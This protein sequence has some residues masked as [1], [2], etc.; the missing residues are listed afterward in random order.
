MAQQRI[1]PLPV[2]SFHHWRFNM[3]TF[4]NLHNQWK[5]VYYPSALRPQHVQSIL[6][7]K[8][9][10]VEREEKA[11]R[12]R[13][14][15]ALRAWDANAGKAPTVAQLLPALEGLNRVALHDVASGNMFDIVAAFPQLSAAVGADV[16][17][18]YSAP[19][20]VEMLLRVETDYDVPQAFKR[21]GDWGGH[22]RCRSASQLLDSVTTTGAASILHVN[23]AMRTHLTGGFDEATRVHKHLYDLIGMCRLLP[24]ADTYHL[25]MQ[26]LCLTGNP[27]DADAIFRFLRTNHADHVTVDM[28]H[29][30][31]WGWR[32]E[33]AYD[34]CDELW[35]ELVDRRVPRATP[36]IA[37]EYIRGIVE[38]SNAPV[39]ATATQ[40]GQ[41]HTVERKRI[42]IVLKQMETLGVPRAHLTPPVVHHVEQALRDFRMY[43][44]RFYNWGR[45][46]KQFDFLNYRRRVGVTS[47]VSEVNP[48]VTQAPRWVDR[49]NPNAAFAPALTAE[50]P[51]SLAM[52][53]SWELTPLEHVLNTVETNEVNQHRGVDK[54]QRTSTS[55]HQRSANWSNMVPETRYD[56]L[57]GMT[58]TNMSKLG[59]RRHLYG[60]EPSKQDLRAR[61]AAVVRDTLSSARRVRQSVERERT[62]RS[63]K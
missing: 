8:K 3:P 43:R 48:T 32:L 7:A 33:K 6:L 12:G 2:P 10:R 39:S 16:I 31:L 36:A 55:L 57:Y 40:F 41:W 63:E 11:F 50:L 52:R 35:A 9:R 59:I 58:A 46:V 18:S 26:A 34:R 14:D 17:A 53:P 15:A 4:G 1:S 5:G 21:A 24:N 30:M 28:Y 20:V 19:G 62:H 47:D 45:S 27:H 42:P 13:R 51:E 22:S 54:F 37:D 49:S 44:S 38:L 29:T 61:D 23:A 60:D 56:K 25:V